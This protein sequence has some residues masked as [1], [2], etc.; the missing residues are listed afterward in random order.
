V[1]ELFNTSQ[2]SSKNDDALRD[3]ELED[4]SSKKKTVKRSQPKLDPAWDNGSAFPEVSSKNIFLEEE[5]KN[6]VV[7]DRC[8]KSLIDA[9][10]PLPT[11]FSLFEEFEIAWKDW[12]DL[13]TE[14]QEEELCCISALEVW[15]QERSAIKD[16]NDSE[17]DR[18]YKEVETQTSPKSK[19]SDCWYTPPEIVALIQQCLQGI[20]LDPCAD[21]G[22]HIESCY[23]LTVADDGLSHPWFGRVFMNPPYSCPGVWIAKLQ[24]EFNSGR[25]EEAIALVP[26]ATDTKWFHP[27]I[28]SNLICFWKGRIKF[29]D[30]NYQPKMPARQSHALIYWGKNQSRFRQVFSPFGSFNSSADLF[31]EE[32][33]AMS[34]CNLHS[35]TSAQGS[36]L[37]I[38]MQG[39]NSDLSLLEPQK[40]TLTAA[41]SS[42]SS[43][44]TQSLD[45]PIPEKFLEETEPQREA[46]PKPKRRQRKGC[47]YKYIEIKKL[48]DGTVASYP[49]VMGHRDPSNPTHWRWGFNWEEKVDGEWKNRSLSVKLGAIPLIQSMQK[50]GVDLAEIIGFIRRSKNKR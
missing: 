20:T 39:S 42:E 28:S 13:Q 12:V 1:E 29:L 24:E 46:V 9:A 30:V 17:S 44:L 43:T 49:R 6:F 26:A 41:I 7:G 25:V 22:K 50:E 38:A 36:A 2:F 35:L 48:K 40:L 4:V 19:A 33:E 27:L 47:L 45:N 14:R 37:D 21:D 3:F 10:V 15:E 31:L 32:K 16:D 8:Q 18:P 34:E 11:N 5:Q 23:H